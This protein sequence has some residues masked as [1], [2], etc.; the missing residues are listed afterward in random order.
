MSP[1]DLSGTRSVQKVL[2]KGALTGL[3]SLRAGYPTFGSHHRRQVMVAP[4]C[5]TAMLGVDR[6]QG[7]VL[8]PIQGRATKTGRTMDAVNYGLLGYCLI[9]HDSCVLVVSQMNAKIPACLWMVW[10]LPSKNPRNHRNTQTPVRIDL[11]LGCM[12]WMVEYG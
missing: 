9:P 4:C 10:C 5:W 12:G 11:A 6:E 3:L 8:T 2:F 7:V 1:V